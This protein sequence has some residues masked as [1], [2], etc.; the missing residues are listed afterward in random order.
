VDLVISLIIAKRAPS[1]ERQGSPRTVAKPGLALWQY[2]A[3]HR[4]VEI[5]HGYDNHGFDLK[6]P[7]TAS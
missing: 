3:K 7:S 2:L 5:I 6:R 1:V 4:A